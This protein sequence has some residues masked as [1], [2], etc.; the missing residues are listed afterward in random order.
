VRVNHSFDNLL[1]VAFVAAV[2]LILGVMW[3]KAL[4]QLLRRGPGSHPAWWA[5]SL[6][7]V[8]LLGPLGALAY[9]LADPA[10]AHEY[11]PH[12]YRRDSKPLG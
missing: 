12:E 7:V 6:A 1:T 10:F 2:A 3:L 5:G 11:L 9:L 8:V 4:I